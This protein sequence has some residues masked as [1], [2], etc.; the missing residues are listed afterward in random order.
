[1][2]LS[3]FWLILILSSVIWL[4]ALLLTGHVYSIDN[5]VNGKKDDPLLIKELYLS[6]AA[7]RP[8]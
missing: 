2:V 4:L 5:A 8:A 3:R 6:N 7:P 1:M